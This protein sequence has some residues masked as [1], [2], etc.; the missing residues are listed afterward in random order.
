MISRILTS[1]FFAGASL[2]ISLPTDI[3][4]PF[5]P[6]LFKDVN[7]SRG[8]NYHYY[9]SPAAENGKPTLVF[10]HG[11][12]STLYDWRHQVSF[13]QEK[14]YGLIALDMLGYGGTAKP[15]DPQ[16]YVSSLIT[17]DVIDI[18]D[19]EGLEQ[20]VVIGHDW[21][22]KT[23]SRLASYYPERFSALGFLS[24]GYIPHNEF[25]TPYLEQIKVAKAVLGYEN[26]GYWDF[27]S[28]E[29]A[30]QLILD[31]LDSLFDAIYLKDTT[32]TIKDF[33][34]LGALA[35]FVKNGRRATPGDYVTPQGSFISNS[36]QVIF[37][38][39]YWLSGKSHSDRI[40]PSRRNGRA[41]E[42]VQDCIPEEN[43]VISK[44]VFFAA[45]LRDYANLAPSFIASVQQNSNASLVIHE[46]DTGR[47]VMMEARDELNSDLLQWIEG[48]DL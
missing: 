11:F 31:N 35:D 20:A 2:A 12:L 30:D 38:D 19:V 43:F 27:F 26:F 5:N 14:G 32:L 44:P 36:A 4:A 17:K 46:Y 6:S 42:L 33:A 10:L 28:S 34:P 29:G 15:S 37:T 3:P 40:D 9:A 39:M 41:T 22:S 8:L 16:A 24:V 7:V 18:L 21:G 23:A 45:A 25:A 1:L 48:L 47:W 13:F